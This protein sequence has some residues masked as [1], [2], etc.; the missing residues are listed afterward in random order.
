[1][2]ED[3]QSR[4]RCWNAGTPRP[5][6]APQEQRIDEERRFER[7][8]LTPLERLRTGVQLATEAVKAVSQ[9]R[10]KPFASRPNSSAC[11]VTT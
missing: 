7:E 11:S 9:T 4:R 5:R 6:A 3:R 1:M 10:W 8:Q 2:H